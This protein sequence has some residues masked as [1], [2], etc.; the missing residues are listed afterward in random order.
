V[1][2]LPSTAREARNSVPCALAVEDWTAVLL[3][4]ETTASEG[5]ATG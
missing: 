1:E 3:V 5:R 2:A 4:R